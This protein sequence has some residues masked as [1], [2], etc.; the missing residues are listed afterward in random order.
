MGAA[1]ASHPRVMG[2]K[3]AKPAAAGIL[4][5]GTPTKTT[6]SIETKNN[7]MANRSTSCGA[8]KA[9]KLAS[10]VSPARMK[11]EAAYKPKEVAARTRGS[12]RR[13]KRPI[14]SEVRMAVT[15]LGAVTRPAQVAV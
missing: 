14:M 9:M 15:P 1:V 8:M 10:E 13:I 5:G 7:P 6:A 3:F 12:K 11:Y 4:G 2:R